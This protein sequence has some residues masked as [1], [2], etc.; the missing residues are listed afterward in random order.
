LTDI[1]FHPTGLKM[2]ITMTGHQEMP[3]KLILFGPAM[4]VIRKK[5]LMLNPSHIAQLYFSI[6]KGS[7]GFWRLGE[8]EYTL[9]NLSKPTRACG[10]RL[11]LFYQCY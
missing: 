9:S 5:E 3:L 7:S 2:V 1:P 10:I 8:H 6:Y 11:F 4:I